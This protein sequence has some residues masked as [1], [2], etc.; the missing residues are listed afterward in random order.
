M[1]Q[2]E[3]I[4]KRL[5]IKIRSTQIGDLISLFWALFPDFKTEPRLKTAQNNSDI[6]LG[7]KIVF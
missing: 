4:S 5:K 2:N 7:L 6:E 1:R 3:A